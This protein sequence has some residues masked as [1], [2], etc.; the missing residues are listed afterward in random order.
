MALEEQTTIV[1]DGSSLADLKLNDVE[2]GNSGLWVF[3]SNVVPRYPWI[4]GLGAIVLIIAFGGDHSPWVLITAI[5]GVTVIT[6]ASTQV[7][8]SNERTKTANEP[9]DV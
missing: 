3:L 8:S 7:R 6:V 9:G 2:R 4:A 1:V 5:L